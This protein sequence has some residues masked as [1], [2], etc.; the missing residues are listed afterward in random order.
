MGAVEAVGE[1]TTGLIEAAGAVK[2]VGAGTTGLVK[3]VGAGTMR[4]KAVG[5]GMAG[6][7]K[8]VKPVR[9]GTMW[10]VE[11]SMT[12]ATLAASAAAATMVTALMAVSL[13]WC[14]G[15]RSWWLLPA[16]ASHFIRNGRIHG[17][18][19]SCFAEAC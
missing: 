18:S 15:M 10:A 1:G 9:A 8:T 13:L 2:A 4:I 16:C 12:E 7:I 17:M 14:W 11:A 19:P 3:T 6:L 5:V